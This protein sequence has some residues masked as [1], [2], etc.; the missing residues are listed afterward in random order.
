MYW[1]ASSSL[2]RH[3]YP[4]G[5]KATKKYLDMQYTMEIQATENGPCFTVKREITGEI[6]KGITP[7]RPWT[8]VCMSSTSPKSRVSG[9]LFF[10]FSDPITVSLLLSLQ[11]INNSTPT[12]SNKSSSSSN[13]NAFS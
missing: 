13:S 3:P 11:T 1:S 8:Q 6:F 7:T 5:F 10:G 9:P 12:D 4:I 2:Y